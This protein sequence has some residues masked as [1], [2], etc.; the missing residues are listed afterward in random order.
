[1]AGSYNDKSR[2][3]L[4]LIKEPFDLAKKIMLVV[5]TVQ[6]GI[7][8][9]LYTNDQ[10]WVYTVAIVSVFVWFATEWCYGIYK[11]GITSNLTSRLRAINNGNARKVFYVYTKEINK[12][13]RV[14]SKI[15]KRFTQNRKEGEWF[16][17]WI[18]EVFYLKIRY[19]L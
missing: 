8:A 3:Y 12:A 1:M 7:I 9:F 5:I 18:W 11:I 10:R 16:A 17:L 2:R 6:A 13:G 4:Y 19:F 14:E 15:H